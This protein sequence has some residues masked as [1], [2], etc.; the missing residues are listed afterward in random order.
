MS[1]VQKITLENIDMLLVDPD[2][3]MRHSIRNI[4]HDN[5]FRNVRLGATIRDI[6]EQMTNAMPDILI[7]EVKLADGDFC[8]FI[9]SLRH[10]DNGTN[11]FLPIIALAWSPTQDEVRHIIRTG[12]DDLLSKP[13]S[14]GQLLGRINTLIK[15]RKPFVVTSDYIGPDRRS[16]ELR[17]KSKIPLID[18]PNT[19]RAKATGVKNFSN[20]Q[21]VIDAAAAEVNLQKL[22][23]H[24]GQIRYLVDRLVPALVGGAIDE[25]TRMA[26]ERLLY[27]AQDTGR[28]LAG[29]RFEHVTDL[30]RSLIEVTNRI[31]AG[32]YEADSKDVN[33]L[34]PLSQAIQGGFGE[35]TEAL[36]FEISKSVKKI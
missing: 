29:T 32:G 22:I 4:L 5:G 11:P 21:E 7:S 18:V 2:L 23:R 24:A 19:L 26:L 3:Q 35:D 28:R 34:R 33:L 9:A 20:V 31:L 12:A 15:D 36:A 14:A 27:I 30:C 8:D 16:K 25:A 6:R 13:L 1:K 10:G 17:E